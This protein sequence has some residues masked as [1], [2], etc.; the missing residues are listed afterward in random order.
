MLNFKLQESKELHLYKR[1]LIFGEDTCPPM[2][3]RHPSAIRS[4]G[5]GWR[6]RTLT[7]TRRCTGL[8]SYG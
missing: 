3:D 6:N 1:L 2:R 4:S 5:S 7:W 8:R